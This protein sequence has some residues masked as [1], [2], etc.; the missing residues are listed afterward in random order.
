MSTVHS[1]DTT[2]TTDRGSDLLP[3][4]NALLSVYDKTGVVELARALV[5][6]GA[7]VI[8][9]GGTAQALERAGVPVTSVEEYTGFGGG[10]G[11]RVKTL[12]PKIHAGILARRDHP[13]DLRELEAGEATPIDLVCVN[14]YP[15][16]EAVASGASEDERIEKI[17]IGGPAMIRAAAKNWKHVAVVCDPADVAHVIAEIGDT[18]GRLSRATRR[19]L[20]HK[21]FA[22][23]S[24]Y[25]AAIAEELAPREEPLPDRLALSLTKIGDLRYG[26]N[27]H[28]ASA[29]YSAVAGSEDLPG[30]WRVLQG[31]ELSYNNWIDLV[32]A[33]ELATFFDECACVIVKHTNPCGTAIAADPADAWNIALKSDPVSA[34][35]G[36]AAFNRTVTGAAAD[37]MA[38]VFLEVVVAPGFDE[39]AL[40]RL[41]KK[42]NLRVVV[43]PMD[44]FRGARREV[45]VLPGGAVLV[46]TDPGRPERT[47]EWKSVSKREPTAEE[48]RDL[49]FAWK[50][51]AVVK[52][53]AIV[54]AKNRRV[55][56]VGAGQMSRVDSV[57]IAIEKAK[58]H[59]HDLT[60]S[61]VGSDAFF[62]FSD[63]PELALAAGATAIAQPGGSKR[64]QDTIDVVDRANAA[65]VFTGT[66]VF[67]H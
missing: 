36:I 44:A 1:P 27:P 21:A 58:E 4:R 53:N 61:V 34:F 47:P 12:H 33:A 67:R 30:G 37:A 15:F 3:I 60:G 31:K 14:L 11:G 63:G 32:A 20:A 19:R 56:G 2:S 59:G 54:F 29:L 5:G 26:E 46:Q 13:E 48:L 39:D 41:G 18:G 40:A 50:V 8:A 62:P 43:L 35:G 65:M 24:Q 10:W 42:K 22:R 6:Q 66:R 52:S 23:T 51:A 45:R 9:S 64:D 55:L 28:Q 7:R 49:E 57:R 25:D 16:E 17:D 38:E